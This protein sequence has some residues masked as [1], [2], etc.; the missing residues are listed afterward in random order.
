[1]ELEGASL[2]SSW[3]TFGTFDLP[4]G[5]RGEGFV[6]I[7]VGWDKGRVCRNCCVLCMNPGGSLGGGIVDGTEGQNLERGPCEEG[8]QKAV[9][10]KGLWAL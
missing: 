6:W 3:A 10:C 5:R 1:M 8:S 9:A 7:L 4:D 2:L